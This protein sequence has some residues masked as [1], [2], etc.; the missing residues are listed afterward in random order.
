MSAPTSRLSLVSLWRARNLASA[1]LLSLF[2]PACGASSDENAPA[3]APVGPVAT[4][5]PT[6]TEAPTPPKATG[7]PLKGMKFYVDPENNALK[8]AKALK[9]TKPDI[10]KLLEERIGKQPTP[11]WV[12]D[13]TTRP[14]VVPAVRSQTVGGGVTVGVGLTTPRFWFWVRAN[15]APASRTKTPTMMIV[16]V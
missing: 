13:W 9:A 11:V 14:C 8:R 12:G 2:I 6:F 4:V 15:S 10:A 7:N 3:A 5:Q 16:L 1:L